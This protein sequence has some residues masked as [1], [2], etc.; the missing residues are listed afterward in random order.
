[1]ATLMD[2]LDQTPVEPHDSY[3]GYSYPLGATV[4]P[5]GTNFSVFS[6]NAT[7]MEI[8][9]FDHEDAR[10][11]TRVVRLDPIL[12]RTLH[13]WH[14]FLP[15]IKSGQMYGYRAD[16]PSNPASGHRFDRQKVL[17]D[18]Y[19]KSVFVGPHYSRAAAEAPGDNTATSMKSVVA[20]LSVF[21]W[22]DDMP[23]N[24]S[25]HK[26]VI[27]EM[28]VAGFTRHP[29]SGV[30][31]DRRG[32]YLGVIEKIPYLQ[33]LGITAVELL[34]V[35]QFDAEDAPP[36]LRNYWGY[37]PVSFFAPHLA[38]SASK[39]PLGCLDEFRTMVKALHRAGIEVILDVVYN[40]TAE[41]DEH[42][43]TLCF[44]GLENRFY[45]IL[46]RDK[47]TYANY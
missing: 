2:K 43:P 15:E 7:G 33:K 32:T 40:H 17:L 22:E 10:Q 28:H 1:M 13:Y 23:L 12:H 5:E 29:N 25:F 34:P 42:G 30:A 11:P 20:D 16:G 37:S 9:L 14:I 47:A 36:G 26:T 8:V 27:Y 38:Y 41:G 24:G 6:A 31:A 18:P 21:D 46:N 35:F 3:V 45:Y 39:D 19:G 44:R 4:T